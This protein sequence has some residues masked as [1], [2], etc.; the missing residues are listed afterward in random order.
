MGILETMKQNHRY[1][2]EQQ[3]QRK[4]VEIK[5]ATNSEHSCYFIFF[6]GK[7]KKNTKKTRW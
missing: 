2:E 6:W 7:K 3:K 4:L 5:D 1:R